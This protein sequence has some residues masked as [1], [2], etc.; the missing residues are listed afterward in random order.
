MNDICLVAPMQYLF[1]YC[2]LMN[3]M[4]YYQLYIIRYF[5]L[6]TYKYFQM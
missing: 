2:I 1:Q 6:E 3:K 5:K 4:K